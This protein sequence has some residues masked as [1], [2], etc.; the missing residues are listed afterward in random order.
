MRSWI[1]AA[2]IAGLALAGCKGK[3]SEAEATPEA[4]TPDEATLEAHDDA[5][6]AVIKAGKPDIEACGQA[7][8]A[9]GEAAVGKVSVT[10]VIEAD[11]SISKTVVE[12][13]STSSEG[14]DACVLKVI[15]G[16]TFPVHPAG[17]TIEYTYPFDVQP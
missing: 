10:F 8:N 16:W 5:V 4:T 12:E 7:D 14:A 1:A 15:Q 11:G 6:S 17:E 3:E 9:G 2:L 13:S